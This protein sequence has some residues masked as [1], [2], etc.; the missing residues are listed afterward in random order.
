MIRSDLVGTAGAGA[1]FL[2]GQP[3]FA[4]VVEELFHGA[5]FV[6]GDGVGGFDCFEVVASLKVGFDTGAKGGGEG[7]GHD[8]CRFEG[9]L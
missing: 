1:G 4:A 6:V 3:Y 2:F 7:A 5:G 8:S 9:R